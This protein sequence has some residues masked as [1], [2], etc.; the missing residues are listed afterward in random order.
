VDSATHDEIAPKDPSGWV[1]SEF[2]YYVGFKL[3]PRFGTSVPCA[4]AG[5]DARTGA[6]KVTAD[7]TDEESR[8]L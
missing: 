5:T 7:H 2:F 4:S 6:T 1:L 8:Q 3:D